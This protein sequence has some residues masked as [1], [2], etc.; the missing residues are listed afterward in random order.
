MTTCRLIERRY[1]VV[2]QN[3]SLPSSEAEVDHVSLAQ[4]VYDRLHQRLRSG[5]LRPGTRLVNRTLAAELGTSTIPVREAISRLVSE[6]VLDFTPGAGAFV[7]APDSN[8]LGEL[9]DVREALE[10]M[11]AVEAARFANDHLLADLRAICQWFR[12]VAEAIP[13]G[14]HATR[15]QFDHWLECE[16]AFHTRLVAASHNRWLVK[17]VK[18]IRVIAQVFAAQ[19]RAPRLLTHALAVTTV[20]QHDTFV[21]I[22]AD[23]DTEKQP[24]G[25]RPTFVWVGTQ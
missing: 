6:G 16:E 12:Q 22:L 14:Q 15:P 2:Y 10:V 17:V 25:C 4:S 9:Y 7:R 18:E 20:S 8:E 21:T 24:P 5:S 13:P 1:I 3:R 23:H 19:K 11:A